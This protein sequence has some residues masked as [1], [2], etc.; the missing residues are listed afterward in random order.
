MRNFCALLWNPTSRP[1]QGAF[2]N[3]QRGAG[4]TVC[5]ISFAVRIAI[6][7]LKTND[8][9]SIVRPHKWFC[10]YCKLLQLATL[11]T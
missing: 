11:I 5:R 2:K 3:K 4:I 7:P 9:K 1:R 6:I 10:Y 8:P